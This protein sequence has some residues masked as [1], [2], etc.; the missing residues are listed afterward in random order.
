M[1]PVHGTV[2]QERVRFDRMVVWAKALT[3]IR[4]KEQT[5]P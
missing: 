4:P 1:L 5:R 2:R 3:Q